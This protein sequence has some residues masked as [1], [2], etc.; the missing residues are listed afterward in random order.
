MAS[1]VSRIVRAACQGE[2]GNQPQPCHTLPRPLHR[3]KAPSVAFGFKRLPG[4]ARRYVNE[5]NPDLPVGTVLADRQYRKF[6]ERLGAR[7]HL[8]GVEM[9]RLAE[10]QLEDLKAALDARS[11]AL[12]AR[13][14]AL[15]E[16]EASL[17]STQAGHARL[18][19]G[20]TRQRRYNL[21]LDL[22][23]TE[24]R[25]KGVTLTKRQAMHSGEFKNIIATIR[26]TDKHNKN[27][28]LDLERKFARSAAFALI[29]GAQ[30][31]KEY[32]EMLYG[33][34]KR[35]AG[36]RMRRNDIRRKNKG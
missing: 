18:Q 31:F 7:T 15:A 19:H 5:S 23:M 36:A 9:L 14:V 33:R 3:Y 13:E 4:R 28:N 20:R 26:K 27:P 2:R 1:G 22:Y 25:R 29:G 21:L 32:Y 16:A 11:V 6:L 17:A 10:R 24:Q 8:P 34:V 30:S 35:G 12:D